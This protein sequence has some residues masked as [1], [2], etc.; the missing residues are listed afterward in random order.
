MHLRRFSS[1]APGVWKQQRGQLLDRLHSAQT[2]VGV[3]DALKA[4]IAVDKSPLPFL[5]EDAQAIATGHKRLVYLKQQLATDSSTLSFSCT[6]CGSCCRKLSSTVLLDPLDTWLVESD[7]DSDFSYHLG[8]FDRGGLGDAGSATAGERGTLL[9]VGLHWSNAP[10]VERNGVA[11]IQFLKPRDSGGGDV[12]CPFSAVVQPPAAGLPK[13]LPALTCTLGPARQPYACALYPLGDVW[14]G[15]S[16]TW[17]SVDHEKCEGVSPNAPAVPL[18]AY[19][20]RNGLGVRQEASHWFKRLAVAHACSGTEQATERA[21]V[22]RSTAINVPRLRAQT[23]LP[24]WFLSSL[25]RIED[26]V[27]LAPN[28]SKT[29]TKKALTWSNIDLTDLLLKIWRDRTRLVWY[30]PREAGILPALL[31]TGLHAHARPDVSQWPTVR[32]A[33]E[34]YTAQLHEEWRGLVLPAVQAKAG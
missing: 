13:P 4:A 9:R 17:Y 15:H 26:S 33:I 20:D 27:L 3:V 12:R 22:G 21:T 2:S 32:D 24:G 28:T 8:Q 34:Q 29:H 18:P 31:T 7:S 14:K 16:H 6:A 11:P 5:P 10:L 30:R 1:K 19:V 25:D 23:T